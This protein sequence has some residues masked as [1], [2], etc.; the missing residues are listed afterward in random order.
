[1]RLFLLL[2]LMTLAPMPATAEPVEIYASFGKRGQGWLFGSARDGRC[3]IALP[4]HVAG[5][6]EEPQLLPFVFADR[7][8]R[9]GQSLD[10]IPVEAVPGAVEAAA[11]HSD[12]AFAPVAPGARA[13][14]GCNSRLGLAPRLYAIMLRQTG[15]LSLITLQG[16]SAAMFLVEIIRSANDADEGATMLLRASNS[17]DNRYLIGGL[18][19]SVALMFH[20]EQAHPGAMVLKVN[21]TDATA[22]ALRFDRIASAFDIVEAHVAGSAPPTEVADVVATLSGLL[23]Q[24][25]PGAAPLERITG[26]GGCW[27]LG[28]A[29]GERR[30]DL[31]LAVPPGQRVEWLQASLPKDCG[32]PS[33]ALLDIRWPGA[34]WQMLTGTC[35]VT[36][37]DAVDPCRVGRTGPFDLRLRVDGN[38]AI[39]R[40]SLE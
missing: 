7:R 17:S 4:R 24:L 30:V 37:P 2:A 8:G 22:I 39:G 16:G 40:I 15:Q 6:E 19:G 36:Y 33:V 12:L 5:P 1:M 21:K 34:G 26:K 29:P 27:R 23:G 11:G 9:S 14:G 18:S 35:H 31:M 13:P 20:E 28:I 32:A 3:W 10:P 25:D 38:A